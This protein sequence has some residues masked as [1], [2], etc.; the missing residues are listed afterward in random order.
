MRTSAGGAEG[1]QALAEVVGDAVIGRAPGQLPCA[2]HLRGGGTAGGY[3]LKLRAAVGG[4][5]VA[6]GGRE[7]SDHRASSLVVGRNGVPGTRPMR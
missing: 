4:R 1:V 3:H 2:A 5:E 6:V 7:V